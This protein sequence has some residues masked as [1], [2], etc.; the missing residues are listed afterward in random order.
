MLIRQILPRVVSTIIRLPASLPRE[1]RVEPARDPLLAQLA[2][3]VKVHGAGIV[4]LLLTGAVLDKPFGRQMCHQHC[5]K[6]PFG[7]LVNRE[8]RY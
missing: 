2:P 6:D 7:D 4:N 3:P 8:R 5:Q 1:N